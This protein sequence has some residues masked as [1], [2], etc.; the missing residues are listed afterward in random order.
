MDVFESPGSLSLR[1]N[2]KTKIEQR[3]FS[4]MSKVEMA[5]NIF[6]KMWFFFPFHIWHFDTGNVYH[7]AL[8]KVKS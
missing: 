3:Y 4:I 2:I 1:H 8:T 7:L 6:L 5:K